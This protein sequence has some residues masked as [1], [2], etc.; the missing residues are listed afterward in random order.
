MTLEQ[1]GGTTGSTWRTPGR[2]RRCRLP[3]AAGAS[4]AVAALL[5]TGALVSAPAGANPLLTLAPQANSAGPIVVDGAGNGYVTWESQIGDANGDPL[6]FCKIPKGGTCTH[7][8]VLPIPKGASWDTYRID[9]PFPV[10]GGK[11]GVVSVVGPSYDYSDVV[12]W[13]SHD[14]GKSFGEP[15]AISGAHYDG[16]TPD[17]VLR[18][19]DADAPYYPDYFSIASSNPGLFYTFTGIG[20]IGARLPPAGFEIGTGAIAGAVVDATLG[21]GK[22]VN[23]GPS[24]STQTIEAFST[25]ADEPELAYVWSPLPGVSGSPGTLEHGPIKVGVGI[26]PRLAGGRAGL[27]LL[28]EDY[29][30]GKGNLTK[31]LL[32][33]VRKWDPTTKTF[34][35]PTL[36]TKVPSGYDDTDQGGLAED[37]STG[38]LTVA[39]PMPSGSSGAVLDIWTLANG[40]SKFSDPVDVARIGASYDGPARLASVGDQGFATWQDNKG[41][42]L[43]DLSHL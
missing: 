28:S 13:T 1:N 16:T 9:Q 4:A 26:N 42:E 31:P 5:L 24:Q 30:S 17:D 18:S 25:N 27:F 35:A 33:D 10:L 38:V 19:P 22:T 21:Y 32:L 14:G 6:V 3:L 23:P 34:G 36:V 12:V 8:L 20:T 39:W 43:V 7:Q 11:A 37:D 15:Q 41:L 40:G 2:H 29:Q